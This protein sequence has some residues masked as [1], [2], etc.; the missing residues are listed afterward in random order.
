MQLYELI[1]LIST[2]LSEEKIRKLTPKIESV[3]QNQGVIL[4]EVKEK[5]EIGLGQKIKKT[6]KAYLQIINF[7]SNIDKIIEIK[8]ELDQIPEI[9]R[10]MIFKPKKKRIVKKYIISPAKKKSPEKKVELKEI[11]EKIDQLLK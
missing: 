10:F 4:V 9:L 5:K 6:G 8:K 1:Y 2:E 3:L 7:Q 11:E